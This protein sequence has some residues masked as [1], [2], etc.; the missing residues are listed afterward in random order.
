MLIVLLMLE[1]GYQ[2]L[3]CQTCFNFFS[4]EFLLNS[5][6]ILFCVYTRHLFIWIYSPLF[7]NYAY[8]AILNYILVH[9]LWQHS[10]RSERVA[11]CL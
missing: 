3:P 5:Y 9:I 4:T 1:S 8:F 11:D 7:I 2:L 6:A 10:G